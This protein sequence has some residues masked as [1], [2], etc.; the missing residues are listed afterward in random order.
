[1]D[2][3][4]RIIIVLK[5]HEMLKI[6][7]PGCIKHNQRQ[8][9]LD[10]VAAEIMGD[11]LYNLPKTGGL[12]TFICEYG[13]THQISFNVQVATLY[14]LSTM[15]SRKTGRSMR[16]KSEKASAL[17]GNSHNLMTG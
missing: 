5:K 14:R 1:M 6:I 2:Y 8:F 9:T 17:R 15:F 3:W 13:H 7:D 12:Y 11:I 16:P 10:G 4:K